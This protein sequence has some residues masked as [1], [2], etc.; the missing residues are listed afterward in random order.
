MQNVQV[1]EPEWMGGLSS[2]MFKGVLIIE[3]ECD[4]ENRNQF[5]DKHY[6][7][8]R[9]G[10]DGGSGHGSSHVAAYELS[11]RNAIIS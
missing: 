9:R 4:L 8:V 3:R 2:I 7:R 11:R 1:L 5:P 10:R 6:L